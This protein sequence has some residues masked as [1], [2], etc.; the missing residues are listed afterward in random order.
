MPSVVSNNPHGIP[1]KR[2]AE[3]IDMVGLS[4]RMKVYPR[5]LSAGELKRVAI[6]RSLINRPEILL[7]DEPTADL[8][9]QTEFM[10][11]RLLTQIHKSGITIIMITHNLNLVQYSTR[12]VKLENGELTPINFS[13]LRFQELPAS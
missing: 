9:V 12:A 1:L 2:A 10:I 4:D 8:D 6:A 13:D 7:A 11:I 5:Q 3:L